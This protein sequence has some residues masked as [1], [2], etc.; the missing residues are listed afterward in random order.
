MASANVMETQKEKGILWELLDLRDDRTEIQK[1]LATYDILV[2]D[3][4]K[5]QRELV[6]VLEDAVKCKNDDDLDIFESKAEDMMDKI[7]YYQDSQRETI[8]KIFGELRYFRTEY[9]ETIR[10]VFDE[11]RRG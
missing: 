1:L 10:K 8:Q 7:S 11:L 2:W 5:H 9:D 6:K 4:Q 3:E